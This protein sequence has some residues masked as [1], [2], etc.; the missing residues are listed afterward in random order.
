MERRR[1][2]A[3]FAVIERAVAGEAGGRNELYEFFDLL[4]AEG[5]NDGARMLGRY[6]IIN[7]PEKF[8][9]TILG[10]LLLSSQ[11]DPAAKAW[12][13]GLIWEIQSR[14]SP[15]LQ[16]IFGP[17]RPREMA[18][19]GG[20]RRI[21]LGMVAGLAGPILERAV[22]GDESGKRELYDLFDRLRAEGNNDGARM[23]AQN[24]V[25]NTPET[26]Y[27]TVLWTLLMSSQHDPM[28]KAWAEG[29]TCEVHSRLSATVQ[30]IL[31]PGRPWQGA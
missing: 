1:A 21:T 29:L 2:E 22:A 31:G 17:G 26:F 18:G 9:L 25:I 28:A 24:L 8:H 16:G 19:L 10:T 15:M 27:L 11:D 6:L 20:G 12:V 30:G 3:V 4:R 7:T 14:M 5:N 23:L 13:K